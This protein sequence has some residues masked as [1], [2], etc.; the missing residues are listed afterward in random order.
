MKDYEVCP[1]VLLRSELEQ[2]MNDL[3]KEVRMSMSKA[4]AGTE[5]VLQ[6]QKS[7]ISSAIVVASDSS[8]IPSDNPIIAFRDFMK[9]N[10]FLILKCFLTIFEYL[11]CSC[12]RY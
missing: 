6:K 4:V 10:I 3:L 9:V 5:R 1:Y 12:H 8:K 2:Y 7:R 11:L